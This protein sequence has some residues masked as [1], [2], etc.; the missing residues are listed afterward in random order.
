V[1]G[2]DGMAISFSGTC[3]Y[4][5][6]NVS[7]MRAKKYHDQTSI[8]RWKSFAC[9]YSIDCIVMKLLHAKSN[10]NSET[11]HETLNHMHSGGMLKYDRDSTE[12]G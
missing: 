5:R 6:H 7:R 9:Y 4:K 1:S 2:D 12:I 8:F 11:V 10:E 3:S